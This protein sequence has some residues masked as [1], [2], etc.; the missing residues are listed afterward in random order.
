[1]SG[2]AFLICIVFLAVVLYLP[3]LIKKRAEGDGDRDASDGRAGKITYPYV[4][5][6]PLLTPAERSFLGVL[7]KVVDNR[8]RIYAQVRLADIVSIRAGTD[9]RQRQFALNRITSKHVDFVVCDRNTL[10]IWCAI[11]LDDSTHGREDRK[12]RDLFVDEVFK[13]A[14]LPLVRIVTRAAYQPDEVRNALKS[15]IGPMLA[16]TSLNDSPATAEGAANVIG[17]K[18]VLRRKTAS[19]G[20]D[21]MGS[22]DEIATEPIGEADQESVAK[23]A[24]PPGEATVS[25]VPDVAPLCPKCSGAT[26]LRTVKSGVRANSK[27]WGCVR[28]PACRGMIPVQEQSTE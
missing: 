26:V 10:D 24:E 20:A 11:E 3:T 17:S 14:K 7:E 9:K 12:T 5:K 16:E 28:Y 1:M 2:I 23:A 27:L 21:Q 25:T 13:A 8:C 15:A 4:K 22:S 6:G 19:A 18:L